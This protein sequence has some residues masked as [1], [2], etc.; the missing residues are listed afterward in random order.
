MDAYLRVARSRGVV[1]RVPETP[2]VADDAAGLRAANARLRELLAERDERI[3]GQ[4]AEIAVLREH[5]AALQ[6]QV[7]DLAARVKSN[8][9]N[10]GKP[11]SSDGLAKPAPKSLRGKSGRKPGRPKGQPG[12]TMRLSDHPDKRVRH[13]PATC[14]C[15]GKS[16]KGA[17]VTGAGRRQVTGIAPVRAKTTGHQLLTLRCGCGCETKAQAPDGVTAAVQYGPRLTGTGICLW[18]G[19][20]LSRDRACRALS[21]LFGCAPAPGALAAAARKTAGLI[22]PALIAITKYLIS[23]EVVHL[24]ETGFRAAGKLAWVHSASWGKFVLVTVHARRGK[25]GMTAAG[26]LPFF[27]GIAVHDAWKPCDTFGNVAGHALCGAHVLRELV[28][29]TGTGTDPGK[30][31]AQQ[32]IDALLALG[33][34]A[35]AARQDGKDAIDPKV[36]AGHEDWYGKAAAA[37]IALNAGR[38]GKLQEKRHALATRMQ[39]REDDYLRF[40]RDLRVPFTNNAAEQAIRMSKL[41]IKVSGCMRSM[42]GA[43]EFCAIRSYLATTARHGISALDALTSAFQGR[44]WIPETG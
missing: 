32:A 18:H 37:G 19:Q 24:D 33:K 44:P 4:D 29:V 43:G 35:E 5:L 40:A 27:T 11:P 41:R 39:A 8:S 34:A 1:R 31:W 3:A 28:A 17:E 15:C 14:R 6:S 22:A 25:D 2:G 10:S 16:L 42:T 26:V 7:A 38:R 9:R 12:A 21:E 23:C 20:F 36:L 30:A 13:R